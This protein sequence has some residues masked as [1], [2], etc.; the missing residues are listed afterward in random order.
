MLNSQCLLLVC[1][2]FRTC[3]VMKW[4]L[5]HDIEFCK[6]ILV[7]R[8]F[9]TKK[10][11]IERGKVWEVIAKK[12]EQIEHPCFRVDQRS[13]RDRFRK[14]LLQFRRKD[15]QEISASGIS[16]EQTELDA[17]LE[18]LNAREETSATLA[19]EAGEEEKRKAAVDK[20]A[21]EEMRKRAMENLS[22]TKRR[23]K[24]EQGGT[25]QKVRKG[26][27]ATLEYLKEKGE[28]E[29]ILKEESMKLERERMELDKENN[30]RL[31]HQ[32]NQMLATMLALQKEQSQQ[33]Q[34]SQMLLM[35]QQQQQGQALLAL[36][37]KLVEK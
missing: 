36:L 20:E 9:E 21:A 11:S 25:K 31:M 4:T 15:R 3:F 8:L 33:I 32:Q 17:I 6:E 7:S 37:S 18:E 35:Q 19:T 29:R 30:E 23:N 27:N 10:K 13:V 26:G 14:L 5:Q 24:S 28:R 34:S 16:P 1:C 12:L 22:E 2:Y